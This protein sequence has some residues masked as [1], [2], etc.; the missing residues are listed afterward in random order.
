MPADRRCPNGG[1]QAVNSS[2]TTSFG[3]RS[4]SLD[5]GLRRLFAWIF[6]VADVPTAVLDANFL[7]AFDLPVDCRQLHLHDRATTLTVKEFPPC[8][9]SNHL[10]A[11]DPNPDCPFRRLQAKYPILTKLH[12][13]DTSLPREI[14][15]HIKTTGPPIFSRP[16]R[17]ASARLA[18]AK[19]E[20]DHVLQL[21]IIRQSDSPWASP[22]HVVPK[23]NA[24]DWRPCGDYRALN[25]ITMPDRYPVPHLQDFASAL[26][27]KTVFSKISVVQAF[28]Q[29]PIAAEDIPKAAVAT[30]FGLFNFLRM[31]FGLRNDSQSF[32]RLS[33]RL[34]RGLPFVHAYI[35]DVLVASRYIREHLQH[36]TVFFDRCQQFGVTLHPVKCVLGATSLEF[37]G[38]LIDS[39]GI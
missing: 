34:L 17:R 21:G 19:A 2:S 31:P 20:F 6:V 32:Q 37:L 18:A 28:H 33:D 7:A 35:D 1:H 12:F 11:P 23:P 29:I 16:R 14:V 9:T 5:I 3:L 30:P 8:S 25:N 26:C 15:H 38:H 39:N 27:G 4:L 24:D 10:F 22:L 36:L 13:S